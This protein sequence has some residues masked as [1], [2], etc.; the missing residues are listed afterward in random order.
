MTKEPTVYA[1]M[2]ADPVHSGHIR[3]LAEAAKLGR[4]IVGLLTDQAIASYKRLP[5]LTFEQRKMVV[6]SMRQVAYVVPQRTL[7]YAENLRTLRPDVVVHGDDWRTGVQSA[8]RGKVI[9]TLREW[10][11]RLVEMP[12]TQGISSTRFHE[13]LRATGTTPDARLRQLRRLIDAKP[14]VRLLEVHNGLT[15]LIADSAQ[16]ECEHGAREFDGM[17]ASSFTDATMRG[18]PDNEAVD[19]S[20]RMTTLNDVLDVTKK[21]ILFDADT[22]GHPEHLAFTV[23]SLERLGISG[24]VIEDK[25]GLK[26]NSLLGADCRQAQDGVERFAA[27]IEAAAGSRVT[28]DFLIIARI[29]SLILNNG[30]DDAVRRAEAYLDAGADGL[31]IHSRQRTPAEI[32]AF[33]ERY[34]RLDPRKPLVVT[35]SSYSSVYERELQSAGANVVVYANQMLRAAYPAMVRVAHSILAHGRAFDSEAECLPLD[36]AVRLIPS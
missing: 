25:T 24:L 16:V 18:K 34:A 6:E 20:A 26:H 35:P 10:G 2:A 33:C 21:P 11:G 14:L 27:K 4:V 5:Y 1:A 17:W 19:F 23:R 3:V 9:E 8:I 7:D 15:G 36:E 22:G 28:G 12:Y 32:F 31:M 29:E 13:Q 30:L